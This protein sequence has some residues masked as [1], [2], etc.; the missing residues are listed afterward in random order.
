ML[1]STFAPSFFQLDSGRSLLGGARHKAMCE[2]DET[3]TVTFNDNDAEGANDISSFN[4]CFEMTA[5]IAV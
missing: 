2:S 4:G 1:Q 5:V 3:A